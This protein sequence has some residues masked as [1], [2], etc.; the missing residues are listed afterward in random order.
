MKIK[1][2]AICVQDGAGV[3]SVTPFDSYEE[4]NS[5]IG[6]DA[7]KMYDTI[8][9]HINSGIDVYPGGAEVVDGEEIYGWSIYPL[10][11]EKEDGAMLVENFMYNGLFVQ[12]VG[13]YADYTATFKEWT[14]DP[15]IAVC[16]CSDGKERLIPSCCL[17]G[18]D[19]KA[20][21]EQNTDNKVGYF[22]IPSRS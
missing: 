8:A 20:C 15:G 12:M 9:D 17:N 5:F 11:L 3:H 21:P 1:Y 10:V 6:E 14:E 2:L 4:A 7:A 18:F 22:G 16:K 13:G 19:Y